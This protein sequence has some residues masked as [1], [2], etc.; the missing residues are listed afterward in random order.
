MRYFEG[1]FDS[2]DNDKS[3]HNLDYQ[4][5]L[6]KADNEIQEFAAMKRSSRK[7]RMVLSV[8]TYAEDGA[9]EKSA[10]Y[11]IEVATLVLIA[12]VS[13]NQILLSSCAQVP[14][15]NLPSIPW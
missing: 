14:F 9:F 1:Q 12:N 2:V 8:H 13:H 15:G 7:L 4:V 11:C 5:K 6:S 3:L 10:R